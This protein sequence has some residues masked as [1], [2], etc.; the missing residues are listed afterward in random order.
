MKI[1]TS[2][3]AVGDCRPKRV[4]PP[5]RPRAFDIDQALD[6]ALDLFWRKG[7]EGTSL[8]DLTDAIGINRPSLYAAFGNKEELFQKA[9]DRYL[10][11]TSPLMC[12][13]LEQS[14]A[15]AVVEELLMGATASKCA[16]SP[17]GCLLVNGALACSEAS[18]SIQNELNRRRAQGEEKLRDRF[19]R[20]K[21]D[22][23]LPADTNCADLARYVMTIM[24]GLSVQSVGGATCEELQSVVRLALKGFPK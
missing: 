20:A 5:G 3:D 15:R 16:D 19:E 23:D 18:T 21:I 8:A 1:K 4:L 17:R 10:E 14:T 12:T 24:Q 6:T 7:Y 2:E 9:L 22:G 13:A 11:V